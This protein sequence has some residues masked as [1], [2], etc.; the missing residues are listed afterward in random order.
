M[1]RVSRISLGPFA[2]IRFVMARI[3]KFGP[4]SVP[5]GQ[6]FNLN[7][8]KRAQYVIFLNLFERA[9]FKCHVLFQIFSLKN[10]INIRFEC[11]NESLTHSKSRKFLQLVTHIDGSKFTVVFSAIGRISIRIIHL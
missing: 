6:M 3:T 11:V 9:D 4:G 1:F 5:T 7:I 8:Y 2:I 10:V